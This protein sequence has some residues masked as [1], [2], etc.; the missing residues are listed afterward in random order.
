MAEF[1]EG[2]RFT[3][4]LSCDIPPFFTALQ[5][6]IPLDVESR[7]GRKHSEVMN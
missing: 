3:G 2:A 4:N 6:I 5:K 7:T 1:V